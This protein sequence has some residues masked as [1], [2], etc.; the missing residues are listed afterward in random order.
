MLRLNPEQVSMANAPLS[1]F[2]ELLEDSFA[3][4]EELGT[5]PPGGLFPLLAYLGDEPITPRRREPDLDAYKLKAIR[6]APE[7]VA[8]GEEITNGMLFGC[9]YPASDEAYAF[10]DAHWDRRRKFLKSAD[11]TAFLRKIMPL[12]REWLLRRMA[13][14]LE[15]EALAGRAG[16][17]DNRTAARLWFGMK[18]NVEPFWTIPYVHALARNGVQ[19]ILDDLRQGFKNQRE[20]FAASELETSLPDGDSGRLLD[21]DDLDAMPQAEREAMLAGM[22][23]H[24]FSGA[25]SSDFPATELLR[26]A[27][28]S[29]TKPRG[30]S[31]A[32]STK[33]RNIY[34]LSVDV[35]GWPPT[36]GDFMQAHPGIIRE[37]EIGGDQTLD[38]L[39]RA[40]FKAFER[41]EMHA[42]EF[43]FSETPMELGA[44]RYVHPHLMDDY[45]SDGLVHNAAITTLDEFGLT[46]GQTFLYWFDFGDDWWHGITVREVGSPEPRSRYPRTVAKHGFSPPQYPD[47]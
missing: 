30:K 43:Q 26:A 34:R 32:G 17:K 37:I 44:P 11:F 14:N 9:L 5:V 10:C 12:E 33:K 1:L 7:L 2:R 25:D 19:V 24:L 31:K 42:Y 8:D 27:L 13:I 28:E 21:L 18:E 38:R 47:M 6:P 35:R 15:I 41:E 23:R 45:A 40:I 39:H 20:A 29:R 16:S 22:M 4:H 36:L 46:V 3:L